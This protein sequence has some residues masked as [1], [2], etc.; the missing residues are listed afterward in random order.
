MV[1]QTLLVHAIRFRAD[2]C[3]FLARE[4][5]AHDGEPIAAKLGNQILHDVQQFSPIW[6][7]A[8]LQWGGG[9]RRTQGTPV[10]DR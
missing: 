1:P 4:E 10:E 6:R 7:I 8:P 9:A 2:F 5:T 3:D